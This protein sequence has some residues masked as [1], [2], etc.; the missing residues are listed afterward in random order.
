[1][2]ILTTYYADLKN[3]SPDVV[4]I[5]IAGKKPEG[6]GIL[7]YKRLAPSWSIFSE[8]KYGEGTQENYVRRFKAEILGKLS[9]EQVLQDLE[10]MSGGKDV[11]LCCYE[12]PRDFCHRHIVKDWLDGK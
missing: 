2:K 5:S 8:Y 6:V 1:M 3:L 11:A 9:R 12:K 10:E 4:P 7:E